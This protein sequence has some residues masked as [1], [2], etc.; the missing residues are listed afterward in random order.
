[1]KLM[2]F[3]FG[4]VILLIITIVVGIYRQVLGSHEDETVHL[5][6]AEATLLSQQQR[7]AKK[8]ESVGRWLKWLIALTALYGLGILAAYLRHVWIQ[9]AMPH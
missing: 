8:I 2:P 1:M 4:W 3:V 5:G 9:S 7:L 6:A